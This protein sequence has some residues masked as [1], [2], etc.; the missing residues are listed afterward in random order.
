MA[1]PPVGRRAPRPDV[2]VEE[3]GFSI[4]GAHFAAPTATPGLYV[5]ATPI[6]N[7]DDVSVRAL[8]VLAGADHVFCEDT[9]VTRRLLER[10]R[11]S[12]Q[13]GIYDDH[14]GPRARAAI[15]R[16]LEA[17][18]SVAL[19]SDAG[20]PLVSDPGFKLVREA[21]EAGHAVFVVPGPSALTAA[22]ACAGIATDRLLFAGFLPARAPARR[23]VIAELGRVAA[24]LVIYESP[25]RTAATLSDLAQVLGPREAAVAREL[26]KM[27]EEVVR[28]PLDQLALRFADTPARGEVVIL[29]APA[30][31]TGKAAHNAAAGG[32]LEAALEAALK[33]LSLRDAV[34]HVAGQL[35]LARAQVYARALEL[36]RRRGGDGPR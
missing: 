8:K 19:V 31:D 29:V 10:Y 17:G 18:K 30:D 4:A 14:R 16:N 3:R 23:R 35:G 21:R 36:K 33:D 15:M 13:L 27:H 1:D 5:V 25:R 22:A 11:I 7:L 6:G 12:A 34:L 28:L 9:R 2:R 32:T 26:T 20:T 24:T